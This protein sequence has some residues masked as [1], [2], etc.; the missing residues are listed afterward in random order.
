VNGDGYADVLVGALYHQNTQP[1]EGRAYL[2]LGSASGPELTASWFADGGQMNAEYGCSV[3]SA[4][5]VN[6]DGYADVIVGA[7]RYGLE[8]GQHVEGRA[9]VY[10]GGNSGLSPS[11]AW[12]VDGN[13]AN[14]SLGASVASAGDVNGDG[15]GGTWSSVSGAGRPGRTTKGARSSIWAHPPGSRRASCGP[16]R[17][18]RALAGLGS[19]VASAGGRRRGWAAR[20]PRRRVALR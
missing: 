3:A 4:G 11:A 8:Q 1:N 19:S 12:T 5:D 17:A 2:F 6:G 10:L 15:Y 18:I 7:R 14:A 20:A 13:Q 9:F 16:A